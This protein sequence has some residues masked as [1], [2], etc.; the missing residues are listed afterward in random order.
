MEA[1]L[2]STLLSSTFRQRTKELFFGHK[3]AFANP[4]EDALDA[5]R[6]AGKAAATA[7]RRHLKD[8][9]EEPGEEKA[10]PE[11]SPPTP[12]KAEEPFKDANTPEPLSKAAKT[13]LITFFVVSGIVGLYAGYLSWKAN[14]VF[15]MSTLW[16]VV[17]AFFAFLGGISYLLSYIIYR[18]KETQFV[19]K[20]KEQP[21][22]CAAPIPVPALAPAPVEEPV[23]MP[24]EM[25]PDMSIEDSPSDEF[26]ETKQAGGRRRASP[27]KPKS[28]QRKSRWAL[29]K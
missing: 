17:F 11:P 3:E 12:P 6:K 9:T 1:I 7:L 5:A 23:A 2:L 29:Y 16:K 21:P 20:M 18:W 27:K 28:Y 13:G 25:Q 26:T 24:E 22:A 14:T 10:K 15:E 19:L 4:E 8:A